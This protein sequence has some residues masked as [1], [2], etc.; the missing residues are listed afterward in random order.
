MAL[1]LK[2]REA[3]PQ[4]GGQPPDGAVSTTAPDFACEACGA[5]MQRGQDWCLECGT[6]APGRLGARPGWRAAF[7]VVGL[8]TLLL[9]CAVVAGY[10]ALTSDAERSASTAPVGSADPITAQTPGAAAPVPAQP[11]AIPVQPGATG[12]NTTAPPAIA[13]PNPIIPVRPPP[14]ATNTPLTPPPPAATPSQPGAT[15]SSATGGASGS[16]GATGGSSGSGSSGSTAGEKPGPELIALRKDAAKTYNQPARAGAE[17][18][19]AAN[20]V[21]GKPSTVWDVVVPADGQPIGAGLVIDLGK[22]YALRS[23]RLATPTPGFTVEI[24]GAKSAKQLPADVI[25]KRWIH[26]TNKKGVTD[27]GLIRLKGKGDGVKVE[28][29]LLHI[30]DAAEPTDPRVA[31]GEVTLRGT[32]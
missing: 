18:G 31:I 22:P 8:T 30:T 27:G 3:S 25:D 23:L 1:L 2:D 5:A 24:Y 10:A 14:P 19:P 6:A 11:G 16:S 32:R 28:L 20:A 7:T 15:G 17:F 21:D 29:L 12:P 4:P 9:L 13:N 26:L